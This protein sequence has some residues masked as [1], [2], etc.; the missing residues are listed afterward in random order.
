MSTYRYSSCLLTIIVINNKCKD[1]Y[2]V[3]LEVFNI[4]TSFNIF[5]SETI[6]IE[7]VN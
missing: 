5:I 1:Y 2:L 6:Q 7:N 3:I 4:M